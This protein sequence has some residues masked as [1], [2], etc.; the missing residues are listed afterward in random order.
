M[1]NHDDNEKLNP[2]EK[3]LEEINEMQKNANIPEN[4]IGSGKIKYRIYEENEKTN[5][6][7]TLR[8]VIGV[9]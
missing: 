9:D 6:K 8:Y 2:F 5:I 3:Q 4:S 7:N 1:G